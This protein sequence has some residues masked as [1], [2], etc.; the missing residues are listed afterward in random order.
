MAEALIR[1]N[2]PLL[3]GWVILKLNIRF[4]G[5]VYRQHLYTATEHVCDRWTDRERDRLRRLRLISAYKVWI[6]RAREKCSIIANR[7]SSKRFQMR[8]EVLSPQKVAQKANL[9]F[10]WIKFK[11]NQIKSATKCLC[12]KTSSGNV[13]AESFPYLKVYRC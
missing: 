12:V 9:S 10:L 4:K 7:K 8:Y 6:V 5:F 11:F 2:R 1:R 13:V 3:K